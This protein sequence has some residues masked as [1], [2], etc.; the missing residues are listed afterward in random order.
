M[1]V[2]QRYL[3]SRPVCKVTFRLPPEAAPKAQQVCLVGEFNA[4]NE[5]AAPIRR[6][7]SGEFTCTLDLPLGRD[8]QFRYLI[9]GSRWENDGAADAYVPCRHAGVEN[10]V[11]H[12]GSP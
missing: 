7:R 12:C 6:L 3:T 1:S 10:S 9:D 2:N 11:G 8:Y 5:A 4:W